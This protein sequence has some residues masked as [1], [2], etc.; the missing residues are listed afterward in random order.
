MYKF[1]LMVLIA[2]CSS[3]PS[4]EFVTEFYNRATQ[5]QSEL[6]ILFNVSF[7]ARGVKDE[8]PSIPRL[9]ISLNDNETITLPGIGRDMTDDE[10]KSMPFFEN[11][12]T[13]AKKIGLSDSTAYQQVKTYCITIV[14]LAHKLEV[15][16]IQ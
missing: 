6:S 2:S 5:H 9:E 11:M 12:E 4:N 10:I 1:I 3:A 8:K 16:K 7:T 15:Y 13:Y 14:E